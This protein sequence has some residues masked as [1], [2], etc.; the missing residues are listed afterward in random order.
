MTAAV[1]AVELSRSFGDVDAVVGVNLD[2]APGETYGF[3]GPNGAGKTT[4][5]RML[6]TLLRPTAGVAR[7]AGYDV[8]SH[9]A[10]VRLRIGV[11]LQATAVDPKQTGREFLDLQGRLYGLSRSARKRRIDELADIVDLGEA[12]DR[13]IRTY[14]GGMARRIDLAGAL[15]H[16]PE[17]V[18]LDEPTSGL[19]PA[20]RLS[21][22]AE[23][24]RLNRDEGTTVFLTT[25]YLE[26]ADALARRIGIIDR[27]LIVT[28]GT[29]DELKRAIGS[30]IVVAEIRGDGPA[31]ERAVAA[32]RGVEHAELIGDE[33]I[34]TVADGTHAIGTIAVALHEAGIDVG[35]LTLRRPTLDDVFLELTGGHLRV[36]AETADDAT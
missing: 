29:P 1:Q 5:V 4:C 16:E 18:F 24:E 6:T 2:V 34:A 8:A 23:I 22:W 20:S 15:V 25:Q 13:M 28:E 36:D 33:L 11:A 14:S 26:E 7:V 30:D 35:P 19:D 3:L 10:E 31:A 21:V 32:L 9:P 17:V 12:L 27:G